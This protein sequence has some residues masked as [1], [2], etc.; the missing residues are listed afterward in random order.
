MIH[1]TVT[2]LVP[3]IFFEFSACLVP[4][5]N[6]QSYL[7]QY[8]LE[9][10]WKNSDQYNHVNNIAAQWVKESKPT[11]NHIWPQRL[12][13]MPQWADNTSNATC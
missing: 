13:A 12:G 9:P 5:I 6:Y 3:S 2:F 7:A 1:A 10:L 8:P 4:C 11:T